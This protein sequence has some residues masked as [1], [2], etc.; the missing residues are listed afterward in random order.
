MDRRH[1]DLDPSNAPTLHLISLASMQAVGVLMA[2]L[3]IGI[4]LGRLFL[5]WRALRR[6]L[7]D[8]YFNAAAAILVLPFMVVSLLYL[9]IEYNIQ[10]VYLGLSDKQPTLEET[11]WVTKLSAVVVLLFWL[12]IYFAKASFLALYWQIF[13]ISPRFRVLWWIVAVFTALCFLV[14]WISSFWA[15]GHPSK[16]LDFEACQLVDPVIP[17]RLV[18]IW[19][20]LHVISS[21]MLM[22][23]PLL[24]TSRLLKLGFREKVALIFVFGL[25]LIDVAFD[26]VRTTYSLSPDLSVGTNLSVLWTY[27]EPTVAVIV[28]ALP[29]YKA[30]ISR[31]NEESRSNTTGSNNTRTKITQPTTIPTELD[32]V[33][34]YS[35]DSRG[36]VYRVV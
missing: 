7:L 36:Q 16:Y 30:L 21:I 20:S 18:I 31:K 26:V 25:V 4:T 19:C 23:L 9:P 3:S 10:L 34:A 13:A 27:M 17:T 35:L 12:I 8:D 6:F 1:G 2:V 32:N 29:H 11:I 15:C 22:V 24:M 28:C 14:T 5:R 33:S